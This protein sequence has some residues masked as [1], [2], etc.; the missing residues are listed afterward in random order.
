[1]TSLDDFLA[2]RIQRPLIIVEGNIADDP[3]KLAAM[4]SEIK[5]R[6]TYFARIFVVLDAAQV[7]ALDQIGRD[8]LTINYVTNCTE[9]SLNAIAKAYEVG[10]HMPNVG[11]KLISIDAPVDELTIVNRLGMDIATTKFVPIPYMREVRKCAI[12][13]LQPDK[14]PDLCRVYEEAFRA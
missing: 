7:N 12:Q 11:N 10:R 1:M 13:G 6:I 2:D 8:A 5:N 14:L 9:D 4:I 3:E